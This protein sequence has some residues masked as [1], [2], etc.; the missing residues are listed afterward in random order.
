MNDL[1]TKWLAALR[2]GSHEQ[3][4]QALRI[5]NKFCCLGVLCD[6]YD[7]SAWVEYDSE[8][9]RFAY[10]EHGGM[11]PN[12]IAEKAAVEKWQYRIARINDSENETFLQIADRL[13]RYFGGDTTAFEVSE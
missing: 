4:Q 6:V 3:G 13:E 2:D 7:N 10:Q 8:H 5:D 11:V 12:E 9:K 1:Q